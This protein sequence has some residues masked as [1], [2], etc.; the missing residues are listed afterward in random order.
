MFCFP[1]NLGHWQDDDGWNMYLR[2]A[3]LYVVEWAKPIPYQHISQSTLNFENK[4]SYKNWFRSSME[5]NAHTY[6]ER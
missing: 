2:L 1:L 4:L 5:K 3:V 6:I